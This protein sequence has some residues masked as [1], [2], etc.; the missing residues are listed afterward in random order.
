LPR[1]AA[2]AVI[3]TKISTCSS[4]CNQKGPGISSRSRITLRRM[5]MPRIPE[6]LSP[7]PV[8][9][10]R[11]YTSCLPKCTSRGGP[12]GFHTDQGRPRSFSGR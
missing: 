11:C 7:S 5:I 8:S 10:V 6:S 1:F 4:P 9:R 2:T 12:D 3:K